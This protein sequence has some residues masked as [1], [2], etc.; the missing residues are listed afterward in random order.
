MID[1]VH[2]YEHVRMDIQNCL[3]RNVKYIIFDDYGLPENVP[4]VKLAVDEYI[5]FDNPNAEITWIG[6]PVG[7]EPRIGRPLVDWEGVIVKI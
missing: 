6:E 7:N 3:N 2:E 5:E 4:S 1:C